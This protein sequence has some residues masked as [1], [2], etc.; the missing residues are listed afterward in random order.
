MRI[1]REFV[2]EALF[3]Y[4]GVDN[5]AGANEEKCDQGLARLQT[6][7]KRRENCKLI[8]FSLFS[9]LFIG[10]LY[11]QMYCSLILQRQTGQV[12]RQNAKSLFN[13]LFPF[14][15]LTQIKTCDESPFCDQFVLLP[16]IYLL[17][18]S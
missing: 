6:I 18:S 12:V 9:Q 16:S 8:L 11:Y 3:N 2:R 15:V 14:N 13:L 7:Q 17:L 4:H 1:F 10:N 5:C